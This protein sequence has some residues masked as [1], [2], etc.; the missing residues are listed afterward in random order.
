MIN[1]KAIEGWGFPKGVDN[2]N[3]KFVFDD[4]DIPMEQMKL[5]QDLDCYNGGTKFCIYDF[6]KNI[7][8][9]MMNFIISGFSYDKRD[10]IKIDTLCVIDG[11]MRNKGIAN[12]YL[13]K[14]IEFGLENNILRFS[15]YPNP[16]DEI[17]SDID[18]INILSKEKLSEFYIK[19]FEKQGFNKEWISYEEDEEPLLEFKHQTYI[20]SNEEK[21]QKELE[22]K[23]KI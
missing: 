6:E 23:L 8:I 2:K 9:F 19:I 13:N 4:E 12:Y 1:E 17:F 21:L 15:L 20:E 3:I 18:K 5:V 7:P 10:R 16:D 22:D 11:T 14:L